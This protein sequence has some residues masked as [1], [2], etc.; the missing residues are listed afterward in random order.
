MH[1][2]K[3]VIIRRRKKKKKKPSLGHRLFELHGQTVK[4]SSPGMTVF[5]RQPVP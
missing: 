4:L 2:N 1:G 5:V 3:E